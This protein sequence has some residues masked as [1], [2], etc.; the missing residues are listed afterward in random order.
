M[1]LH[2]AIR[3]RDVVSARAARWR[4][5][6]AP[7]SIQSYAKF[8]PATALPVFVS[9]DGQMRGHQKRDRDRYARL[10]RAFGGHNRHARGVRTETL[11]SLK[12]YQSFQPTLAPTLA[13]ACKGTD[14]KQSPRPLES[15]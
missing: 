5:T 10:W 2:R 3:L 12:A 1:C 13:R 9:M 14:G 15:T 4:L 6:N 7:E 11:A 8:H